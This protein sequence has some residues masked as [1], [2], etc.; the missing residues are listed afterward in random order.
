MHRFNVAMPS[1]GTARDCLVNHLKFD[2]NGR[3]ERCLAFLVPCAD[4]LRVIVGLD[5]T[6]LKPNAATLK[7]ARFSP[8]GS[9]QNTNEV[10]ELHTKPA[11][12]A[13]NKIKRNSH[14]W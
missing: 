5:N 2:F 6:T 12:N 14:Y 13:K 3:R 1:M 11:D 4:E 7:I 10:S 9:R 8:G